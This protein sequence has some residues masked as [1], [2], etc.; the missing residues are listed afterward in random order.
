[1]S[2]EKNKLL[3]LRHFDEIFNK[4]NLDFADEAYT[5]RCVVHD[6]VLPNVPRGPEGMKEYARTYRGPVP[7][8]HFEP[9][10]TVGEGDYVSARWTV[11]GTHQGTL[12]AL[13]G[14]GRFA[15]ISGLSMYRFENGRIAESWVHWDVLGMLKSLGLEIKLRTT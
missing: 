13:P 1:M 14:T 5:P 11:T 12:L 3:V 15:A 4:G 9:L 2:I 10:D 7:D 6:P 8:L